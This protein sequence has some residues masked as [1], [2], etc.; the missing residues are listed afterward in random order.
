[1]A[2]FEVAAHKYADLSDNG[3]GVALLNDCKYGYKVRDNVLDLNLLRSPTEPD[4]DADFDHHEFTYS[5]LPHEGNLICSDVQSQAIQLNQPPALFVGH[6]PGTAT[7]PVTV[8][9]KGARLEVLK[10][11]EK[12]GC[13]VIRIV[14]SLGCET[15]ATVELADAT[16][17]LVE[18]DL[19][20]W[21][22]LSDFGSGCI[23]VAMKPFEIRTFKILSK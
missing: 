10:K 18:T 6:R 19:L 3:Y 22:N 16:V 20:E 21:D 23:E 17:T 1:M 5:L 8:R 13:L 14:E 7:V 4:P 12:E 11:A 9:G 2:R 15:T